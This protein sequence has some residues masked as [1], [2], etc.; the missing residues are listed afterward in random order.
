MNELW[1]HLVFL[2]HD[3]PTSDPWRTSGSPKL[4]LSDLIWPVNDLMEPS[5]NLIGPLKGPS[6]FGTL[7]LHRV[8]KKPHCAAKWP[9]WAHRT[10]FGFCLHWA[11]QRPPSSL[12]IFSHQALMSFH[13]ATKLASWTPKMTGLVNLVS[14]VTPWDLQVT[15]LDL[16]LISL[17]PQITSLGPKVT[18]LNITVTPMAT[19]VSS[20]GSKCP[21]A[22]LIW[23]S[24][25]LIGLS[26]DI[27][28]PSSDLFGSIDIPEEPQ[29]VIGQPQE[30]TLVPIIPHWAPS[31]LIGLP[32]SLNGPHFHQIGHPVYLSRPPS[33]F[34]RLPHL[35]VQWGHERVS[36]GNWKPTKGT[37]KSHLEPN[38]VSV[39]LSEVI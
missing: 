2:W 1:P 11:L 37:Q 8:P 26:S 22:Y 33:D 28:W 3:L 16:P 24:C 20:L 5:S 27:I 10:P 12:K 29:E 36:G 7:L 23:P 17:D 34:I 30:V 35:W 14:G 19:Q 25:Y 21:L 38:E 4:P 6:S 13:W 39:E 15:S 9:P 18:S 31:Y 32:S